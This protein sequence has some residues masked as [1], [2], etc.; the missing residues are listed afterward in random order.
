M[1]ISNRLKVIVFV[2]AWLSLCTI[3]LF[4]GVSWYVNSTHCRSLLLQKL[5][6]MIP[7]SVTAAHHHLSLF[8]GE[9]SIGNLI[10]KD[11]QGADLIRI[12]DIS[13]D[14]SLTALFKRALVVDAV[15]I[16]QPWTSL[17]MDG[18]GRLNLVDAFS[19]ETVQGETTAPPPTAKPPFNIVV[20]YFNLSDGYVSFSAAQG[21]RQFVLENVG[22]TANGNLNDR[23]GVLKLG[24]GKSSMAFHGYTSD[25]KH[26]DL[27]LA[28]NNGHIEPLVIKAENHFA[29]LLLCGDIYQAFS[30][31]ELDLTLDLDVALA[32][33][34]AFLDL[35]RNDTGRVKALLNVKGRP[36]N[37]RLKLSIDYGGGMIEG[38]SID[39][40][41]LGLRLADRVATLDKLSA[42]TDFGSL[43][44]SGQVDLR[45]VFLQ[46]FLSAPA[47]W[48]Q[49]RFKGRLKTTAINLASIH[50]AGG[51]ING[52]LDALLNFVGKGVS[53]ETLA[54]DASAMIDIN[55]FKSG[56]M[57]QPLGIRSRMNGR[58]QAGTIWLDSVEVDAADAFLSA[59]GSLDLGADLIDAHFNFETREVAPLLSLF[60]LSR[61]RGALTVNGNVTG[62]STNPA[63]SI[64]TKGSGVRIQDIDMGD[65][66][67]EAGL[68]DAGRL[69][70]SALTIENRGS[71]IKADGDIQLFA[72]PFQLHPDMPLD[73]RVDFT[74]VEYGDFFSNG[75][76][77]RGISGSLRG[78]L[79]LS[80][81]VQ[82]LKASTDVFAKDI[83]VGQISLGNVAGKAKFI[84]GTLLLDSLRLT[85][86]RTDLNARGEIRLLHKDSWQ[87]VKDP[88]FKLDL[89]DGHIFLEDF[90]K[91]LTG[92]LTV[93][94]NLEGR[95]KAPR[96]NLFLR[97]KNLD[98]GVQQIEA[99]A[100][101]V[102]AGDQRVTIEPFNVVM[103]GGGV[104]KGEGRID[105]DQS[106]Q[107]RLQTQDLPI[108]S[109]DQV[110]EMKAVTGH[111]DVDILGKGTLQQPEITGSALFKN[112]QIRNETIDDAA[113]HFDF[114]DSRVILSGRHAFDLNA[115]YDL[116]SQAY[117]INL[118]LNNTSLT[119]WF[120]IVGRTE[121]SGS[122]SGRIEAKGLAGTLEGTQ[123]FV[124][125]HNLGIDFKGEPFVAIK[126]L[127]GT[128]NKQTFNIPGF[129]V[130]LLDQGNFSVKGAGDIFGSVNV[131]V[132]GDIPLKA[133]NL[134]VRDLPEIKG[135]LSLKTS[136][137]GTLKEPE[138]N[139]EITIEQGG[140]V[141]PELQQELHSLNGRVALSSTGEIDGYLN[142]ML[143]SGRFE[144]QTTIEL[145]GFLPKQIDARINAASL[146]LQIPNT[147]EMLFNTDLSVRG[148]PDKLIVAGD[149]VL[150]EG[151]YYKDFKLNLLQA[152][153]EEKREERPQNVE[154][155]Y[156]YLKP[157]QFD[158]HLKHR[159]P[160]LVENNI[161]YMEISPD[162]RVRGTLE[163]PIITGSA[164]V[165]N[166]E[167]TYLKNE[168]VVQQGAVDF[169]NPYE[170]EAEVDIEGEVE[171]RE[172][173]ITIALYGPPDRLTVELSSSPPEEDADIISLLVFKKTTYELNTG[174]SG[175]GQSPTVLLAQLLASSFGEDIKESTGIDIL[176]VEAES[177]EDKDSTDRIM[178]TVGKDLSE[179]MTVKYSVESGDGGY[180]QRASTEYKLFENFLVSGFQDTKG[181]YG[182]ELIFRLEF[183]LFQ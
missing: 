48:T 3:A 110:R 166:G 168:F 51:N 154:S 141:I 31:P 124:D 1:G 176:E 177:A 66:M 164:R 14:L 13:I 45:D 75:S 44:L 92:T 88:T 22:I 108:D 85:N 37:P 178:V 132:E 24:I 16:K 153:Q 175:A 96:G 182:G 111:L 112:V 10:V 5:N 131:D 64:S 61:I 47:E 134:F 156:P 157:L 34:E 74:N 87:T 102:Q 140:M 109:L 126:E 15:N 147:L 143:D 183:R 29:S 12:A 129:Q 82:S 59:G 173:R 76:S 32:E 71:S 148:T 80:G 152:I 84:N 146:P 103:P 41:G 107:F 62:R 55:N 91:D 136:L 2:L 43:D 4:A 160:F 172:W 90:H 86:N 18:E 52:R 144:V 117:F 150:L 78:N 99:L 70:V 8:D 128:L 93:D 38:R 120:V 174:N 167:I 151:T 170:T 67:L 89:A 159:Q 7:G 30:D 97:G 35:D 26:I 50:P 113:L 25:F 39:R 73:A 181:V 142:G 165:D 54:A 180:V 53:L 137:A 94:T 125:I 46:G 162:V 139:G 49:T 100:L 149:V 135:N 158:I 56:G 27:A 72:A 77:D 65:V 36:D 161:A 79:V 133:A 106:F 121:L 138:L 118:M 68:N 9:V 127:R 21:N 104:L 17:R 19:M 81:K 179:R 57:A 123:A 40:A 60:G 171:V 33:A 122:V 163:N 114:K 105:Y 6:T 20:R 98:L 58:I 23:S 83:E 145:D 11:R 115:E 155:P 42:D 28:V 63:I 101:D 169:I 116:S 69:E 130:D 119:P 95:L